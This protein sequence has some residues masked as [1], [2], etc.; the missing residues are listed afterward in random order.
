MDGRKDPKRI[1]RVIRALGAQVV[2]LQEVESFHDKKTA[3]MEDLAHLT[4]FEAIPGPTIQRENDY[5]GN[6]LLVGGGAAIRSI[7]RIDLSVVGFEP[8]GAIDALLEFESKKV[9]VV[10]T[11]LGLRAVERKYQIKKLLEVICHE[12]SY[13]LVLLGDVNEW[14]PLSRRLHYIH[15]CLGKTSALPTFPSYLPCLSLD[16]IWVRPSRRLN[17]VRVYK[18]PLTRMASDHMPVVANVTID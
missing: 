13:P 1:A 8:R 17:S 15:R 3:Q 10:V 12:E 16:R 14:W 9:R 7:R 2:G 6:V 4:G 18:S 5:Y 11:H